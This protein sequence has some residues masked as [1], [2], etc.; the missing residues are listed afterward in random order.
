MTPESNQI[1]VRNRQRKWPLNTAMIEEIAAWV[2]VSLFKDLETDISIQFLSPGRMA[3]INQEYLGHEG[4]T[5]V[6]TFD[7]CNDP[8]LCMTG[9]ILICPEVA[10]SQ[11][12]EFGTTWQ[13]E[14]IRYVIHGLLH[15]KGFDD[16]EPEKRRIMKQHENRWVKKAKT[17][18]DLSKAGTV[19]SS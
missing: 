16:L 11:S 9:E 5:D 6:I 3:S 12:E 13:E 4:P 19:S 10:A 1:E 14:T 8:A 2:S 15:L 7:L 18:F 17:G